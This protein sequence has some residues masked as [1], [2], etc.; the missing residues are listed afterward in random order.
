MGLF[1]QNDHVL[2]S[3]SPAAKLI[4]MRESVRELRNQLGINEAFHPHERFRSLESSQSS[5]RQW[6]RNYATRVDATRP[7]PERIGRRVVR[8]GTCPICLLTFPNRGG[9]E[10]TSRALPGNL[11]RES[12]LN[13]G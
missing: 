1:G 2:K 13:S 4:E 10:C 3:G 11:F 6:K 8:G 12:H 9:R 7:S 5:Q